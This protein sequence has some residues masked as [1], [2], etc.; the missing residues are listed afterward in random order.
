MPIIKWQIV[1]LSRIVVQQSQHCQI[2]YRGIHW[3]QAEPQY[4]HIIGTTNA[5]VYVP[6]VNKFDSR[7]TPPTVRWLY[8]MGQNVQQRRWPSG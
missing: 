5:Y 8:R 3:L 4:T 2:N 7:C 1:L 6:C